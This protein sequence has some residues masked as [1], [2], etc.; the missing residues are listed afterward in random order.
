M[1][2]AHSAKQGDAANV[3]IV[4]TDFK[5]I[6]VGEG[7]GPKDA[8]SIYHNA[9]RESRRDGL[10][11][12]WHDPV[13]QIDCIRIETQWWDLTIEELRNRARLK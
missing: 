9:L 8:E 5:S 4:V 3:N 13:L 10:T 7:K 1:I 2:A 6:L 12:V 11:F